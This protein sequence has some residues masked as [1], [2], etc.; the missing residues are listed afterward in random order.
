MEITDMTQQNSSSLQTIPQSKNH[1][2]YEHP[3]T[4]RLIDVTESEDRTSCCGEYPVVH[5][6]MQEEEI[7]AKF[8]QTVSAK[9]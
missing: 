6:S 4:L 2:G 8:C 7:Q 9:Q 3:N 5:G 1:E